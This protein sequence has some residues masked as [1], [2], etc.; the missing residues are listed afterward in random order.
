MTAMSNEVVA[1]YEDSG[2]APEAIAEDLGFEVEAVK[3]ILLQNSKVYRELVKLSRTCDVDGEE[4][5]IQKLIT[6]DELDEMLQVVKDLARYSELDGVRLKAAQRIIDEKS[7][8]LDPVKE[9]KGAQ[10]NLIQFNQTLLQNRR[11]KEK[12]AM[13][14][15]DVVSTASGN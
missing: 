11:A 8:R 6:D 13:K 10:F 5:K 15:L 1:L 2:L 14:V 9:I 4:S 3:A 12:V 7:R